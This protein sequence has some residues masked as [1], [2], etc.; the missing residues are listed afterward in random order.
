MHG[1]MVV[2]NFI[3]AQLKRVLISSMH[4]QAIY[5]CAHYTCRGSHVCTDTYAH[6]M[7]L[8]TALYTGGDSTQSLI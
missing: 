7:L 4:V 6:V 2:F 8:Y 1:H 3:I 5:V